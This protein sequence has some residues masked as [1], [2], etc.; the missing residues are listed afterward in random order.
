MGNYSTVFTVESFELYHIGYFPMFLC[1][2]NNVIRVKE[3]SEIA[4]PSRKVH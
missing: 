2:L 4:L 1:H 3:E